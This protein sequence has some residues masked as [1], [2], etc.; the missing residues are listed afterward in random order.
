MFPPLTR[1]GQRLIPRYHHVSWL[2][3]T[4]LGFVK[5]KP[6]GKKSSAA[7]ATLATF[8]LGLVTA[9]NMEEGKKSNK[10]K[11]DFERVFLPT[12]G[13]L[14]GVYENGRWTFNKYNTFMDANTKL[15][16]GP[17]EVP[18]N[19]LK[20][21]LHA[22]PHTG[23]YPKM[24]QKEKY[25]MQKK[26]FPHLEDT[27][28]IALS[29]DWVPDEI[30]QIDF[31]CTQDSLQAAS[32]DLSEC[33]A[34][35]RGIEE[36]IAVQVS[37]NPEILKI[38][39]ISTKQAPSK[40]NKTTFV[41]IATETFKIKATAE[42]DE[43]K[44]KVESEADLDDRLIKVLIV[45]CVFRLLCSDDE[46][47]KISE[48]QHTLKPTTTASD[49]RMRKP[50]TKTLVDRVK[51]NFVYRM[52]ESRFSESRQTVDKICEYFKEHGKKIPEKQRK[53]LNIELIHLEKQLERV[54]N[55]QNR[56]N[57]NSDIS[58]ALTN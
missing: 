30:D 33:A 19:V 54:L 21:A 41:E 9:A 58:L 47:P 10:E 8:S 3:V 38:A 5:S 13:W 24:T 46:P 27:V 16:A 44:V 36:N 28:S 55:F 1:F 40:L 4:S 52:L 29:E 23:A 14:W 45:F 49:S 43:I 7:C 15:R 12:D 20:K 17:V 39:Q 56:T 6:T 50:Q 11:E 42:S 2:P 51:T 31:K 48:K 25:F 35:L 26:I 18:G 32:Q 22:L 53:E 57:L 34:L 37:R